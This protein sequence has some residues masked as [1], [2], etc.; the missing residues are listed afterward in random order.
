MAKQVESFQSSRSDRNEGLRERRVG[1]KARQA[2]QRW[3]QRTKRDKNPTRKMRL[4]GRC[5]D[6]GWSQT[7]GCVGR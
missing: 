3:D 1:G 5:I 7:E 4:G 6:R 2:S